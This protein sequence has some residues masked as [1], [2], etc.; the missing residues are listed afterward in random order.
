MLYEIVNGHWIDSDESIAGYIIS[1]EPWNGK[2][3]EQ[4]NEIFYY[5]ANKDEM[6]AFI[7]DCKNHIT[8][9]DFVITRIRKK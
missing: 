4:D 1:D 8:N 9:E 6:S 5:F 2:E 3:D 7:L